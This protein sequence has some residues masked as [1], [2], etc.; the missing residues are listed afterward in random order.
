[1]NELPLTVTDICQR[2][3]QPAHRVNWFIKTRNIEPL[4]VAGRARLFSHEAAQEV[5][6]GLA[7]IDAAKS[8]D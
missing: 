6:R 8:S 1:M 5:E 3:N 4:G 7:E 2:T